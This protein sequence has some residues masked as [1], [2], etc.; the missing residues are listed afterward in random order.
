MAP[1]AY[2]EAS[3]AMAKGAARLER[4]RTGLDRNKDLRVTNEVWQAGDQFQD[5]FFLVRLIRGQ[6]TLE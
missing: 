4:W 2:L 3:V 1:E 6:A 5:K